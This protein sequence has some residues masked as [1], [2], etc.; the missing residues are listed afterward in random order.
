[1]VRVFLLT[2]FLF[3]SVLLSAQNQKS[4]SHPSFD[5]QQ[6]R[7]HE[8]EPHRRTIPTDD[9]RLGLNQ[10]RIALTVSPAGDVTS[11]TA[12]GEAELLKLWPRLQGEVY[13]WKFT[14]FEKDGKPVT[15]EVEEYIDL[16]LPN[17]SQRFT[18]LPLHLS[19]IQRSQSRCNDRAA[20]ARALRTPSP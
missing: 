16:S 11:A 9:V 13:Q 7:A 12:D 15:A 17:A 1:M 18:S 6:A 20:M 4:A 10:L 3:S 5:Y 2:P 19:Q 8:I 14:P